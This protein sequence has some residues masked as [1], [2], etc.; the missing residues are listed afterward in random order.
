MDMS[1]YFGMAEGSI[2]LQRGGG[3]LGKG[4]CTG[5]GALVNWGP[6]LVAWLSP[7]RLSSGAFGLPFPGVHEMLPFPNRVAGVHLRADFFQVMAAL[8]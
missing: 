6:G 5:R 7:A 1:L 8:R 3:Y 2:P 4:E